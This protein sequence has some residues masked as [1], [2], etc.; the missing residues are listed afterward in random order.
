VVVGIRT[1][2]QIA[3]NLKTTDWEMLPEEVT[4]LDKVSKPARVYPYSLPAMD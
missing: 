2:E 1:P 4:Q 3:D